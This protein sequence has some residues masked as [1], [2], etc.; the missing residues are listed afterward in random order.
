MEGEQFFKNACL[1]NVAENEID[2]LNM[3]FLSFEYQKN[4]A[5]I[6]FY[7]FSAILK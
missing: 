1:E 7:N 2:I 3:L 6:V 4:V 5:A